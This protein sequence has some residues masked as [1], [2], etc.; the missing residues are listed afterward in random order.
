MLMAWNFFA[1]PEQGDC[2]SYYFGPEMLNPSVIVAST[3][4]RYFQT[5]RV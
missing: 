3:C 2:A 1:V 5:F 4:V